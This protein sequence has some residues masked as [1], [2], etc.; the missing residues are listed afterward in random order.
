MIQNIIVK[1]DQ[2]TYLFSLKDNEGKYSKDVLK[3]LLKNLFSEA[4]RDESDFIY[5]LSECFG[6]DNYTLTSMNKRI[7]E[8]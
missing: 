2:N 7:L 1:I 6:K 3:I 5:A 4:D 8:V